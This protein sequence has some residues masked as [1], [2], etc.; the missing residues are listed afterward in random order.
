METLT[1]WSNFLV[2]IAGASA[3]LVGLVFVALSINLARIIELPGVTGRAAET[4]ILLVGVLAG[5]L[6]LLIPTWSGLQHG[7][8]LLAIALPTWLV[9]V[10]L[11]VRLVHSRTY[12]RLWQAYVRA[13]LHQAA[14][15]PG[16]FAA[17]TLCAGWTGSMNWF[18]VGAV[19]SML[20]AIFSAWILLVEI[21]R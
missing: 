20:T 14:A 10:R 6:T 18:A 11:Q 9:P 12:H 13:L 21:V 2:A 3:A 1:A 8:A 7:A 19:L 15:L 17:A 4:I 16:V 5:A